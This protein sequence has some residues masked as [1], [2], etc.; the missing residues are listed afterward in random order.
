MK[1]TT[2]LLGYPPAI[3]KPAYEGAMFGKSATIH[4]TRSMTIKCVINN[5]WL[6]INNIHHYPSF[7]RY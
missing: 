1:Q 7:N 2:Q 5:V 6:T 4:G 3:R